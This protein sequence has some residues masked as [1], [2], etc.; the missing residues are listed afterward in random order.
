MSLFFFFG[1]VGGDCW[2]VWWFCLDFFWKRRMYCGDTLQYI[3]LLHCQ[4][5]SSCFSCPVL[6]FIDWS[7]MLCS[8]IGLVKAI[9]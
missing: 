3:S 9:L 5:I 7:F 6:L 8:T 2:V 4:N 1:C